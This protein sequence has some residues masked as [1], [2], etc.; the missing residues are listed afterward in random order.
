M[1]LMCRMIDPQFTILLLLI[2]G[3]FPCFIFKPE[4]VIKRDKLLLGGLLGFYRSI[5]IDNGLFSGDE[6]S[7]AAP[8]CCSNG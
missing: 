7:K 6:A 4:S 1:F 3:I 8:C 2:F 5:K